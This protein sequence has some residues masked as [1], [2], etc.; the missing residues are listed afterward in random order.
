M[1]TIETISSSIWKQY[2]SEIK[3]EE[4]LLLCRGY[5]GNGGD[6]YC[7][8]LEG[9]KILLEVD[10]PQ[11]ASFATHQLGVGLTSGHL[12]EFLGEHRPAFD[13]R[14][15]WLEGT[16]RVQISPGLGVDIP[17]SLY[18][19]SLE[20][21]L[22]EFLESLCSHLLYLGYNS[23][24]FGSWLSGAFECG[25][26]DVLDF[27][28]LFAK[29]Q[30]YGIKVIVKPCI[31]DDLF[32]KE[33]SL[34]LLQEKITEALKE[35]CSCTKFIH[36]VFWQSE[37][38]SDACL[39]KAFS[40]REY[41]LL[42]RSLFEVE[43]LEKGLGKGVSLI[44]YLYSPKES[45]AQEYARYFEEL[46]DG[47][48]ANTMLSFSASSGEPFDDHL[49]LHPI[50]K[51]IRFSPDESATPILP[52]INGGCVK[53]GEGLWPILPL[54]HLD[55]CFSR[56][57]RHSFAG[58]I[59][60][61]AHMPS[62]GSLL[63][64]CLWVSAQALWRKLSPDLLAQTWFL[65][66]EQRLRGGW[67]IS[68]LK[69]IR[70]VSVRLRRF[71]MG[72]GNL[73]KDMFAQEL[74]RLEAE[75]LLLRLNLLRTM[76]QSFFENNNRVGLSL[77]DYLQYYIRDAKR[78]LLKYLQKEK[79]LL[80]N[81]LDGEDLKEGFWTEISQGTSKSFVGQVE[82]SMLERPFYKSDDPVMSE[83]FQKTCP[84]FSKS[85]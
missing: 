74:F 48:G 30:K 41:T 12:A 80:A 78:M 65:A 27:S 20:G 46:L 76:S 44:Y 52:I 4:P 11:A 31:V 40:P 61:S 81:I 36:Y 39:L 73:Q 28:V 33:S 13:L 3:G 60:M 45:I 68:L 29:I 14:P 15:L 84:F 32:T 5:S 55:S 47:V 43:A 69:K 6:G 77:S 34:P 10:T 66:N 54:D 22:D 8:D 37:V 79:L 19:A 2:L 23:I 35:F 1:K 63:D 67:K 25:E 21:N 64:C 16:K 18:L 53:Q 56:M 24:L 72:N 82:V 51:T 26:G 62:L 58:A 49:E 7:A 85:M 38:F 9:E 57:Y 17:E 70:E 71:F 83:I 59:T 50:W 75:S 42:E